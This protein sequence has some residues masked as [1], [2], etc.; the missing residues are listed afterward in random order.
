MHVW[1]FSVW[2]CVRR[3]FSII[4]HRDTEQI[5]LNAKVQTLYKTNALRTSASK[6]NRKTEQ[7]YSFLLHVILN[8]DFKIPASRNTERRN[9]S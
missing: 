4:T 2:P 1:E 8:R 3:N 7:I 9:Q 6:S 5:S